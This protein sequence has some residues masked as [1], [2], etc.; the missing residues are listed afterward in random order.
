M[1]RLSVLWSFLGASQG[2]PLYREL[3]EHQKSV[4]LSYTIAFQDGGCVSCFVLFVQ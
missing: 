3:H 2:T 4:H 1:Y